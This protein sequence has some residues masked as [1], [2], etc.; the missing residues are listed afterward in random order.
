MP[1]W[2]APD[3]RACNQAEMEN[4]VQVIRSI[5]KYPP[6]NWSD[7]GL[8]AIC[9][10]MQNESGINP[11]RWENDTVN[12]ERGYGLVGWTPATKYINWA[13]ADWATNYNKQIERIQ[14]EADNGTQWFS[15]DAAPALGFPLSP[16]I[17]LSELLRSNEN[18][19][20]LA[21]YFILYYEHPANPNQPNRAEDARSWYEFITGNPAPPAGGGT[22]GESRKIW[23]YIGGS[24]I[25]R[26]QMLRRN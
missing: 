10:N 8:A 19:S 14:W 25:R 13:G 1:D 15:N 20:T 16:P 26:R 6:Y 4:N 17:T 21:W 9:G 24:P 18:P 3:G 5:V 11:N 22:G 7:E 23:V 12:Y 2:I